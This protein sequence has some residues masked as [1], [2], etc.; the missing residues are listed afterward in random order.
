MTLHN[1]LTGEESEQV[2]EV[3]VSAAGGFM[4][5]AYP[6]DVPGKEEF[7]GVHFHSARWRHD[8]TLAGKRVGVIGNACSAYV[9]YSV[10]YREHHNQILF[11]ISAQLIPNISKDPTVEVINFARTPQWYVPRVRIE[12]LSGFYVVLYA[13]MSN[14][15][16]NYQYPSYVKWAFAH[17][18]GVLRTYRNYVA[19]FVS[20]RSLI[21]GSKKYD[22]LTS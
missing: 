11:S 15:Q 2:V 20:I 19:T 16:G 17:V 21:L 7:K 22:V 10:Y 8:V 5:P 14:Y 6:K 18:P 12:V 9:A 3:I 4:S 13:D 1:E